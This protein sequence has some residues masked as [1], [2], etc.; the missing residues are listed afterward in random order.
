VR[1]GIAAE[2]SPGKVHP[3]FLLQRRTCEDPE[4][5]GEEASCRRGNGGGWR[6]PELA[7]GE[8]PAPA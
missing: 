7:F 4:E 5:E 1:V 3:V 8:F 6:F 2:G